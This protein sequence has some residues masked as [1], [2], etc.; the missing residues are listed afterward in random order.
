MN[1]N[2]SSYSRPHVVECIRTNAGDR[3]HAA[4]K[5]IVIT[6]GA[7]LASDV[8]KLQHGAGTDPHQIP[9]HPRGR[10]CARLVPYLA[11]LSVVGA[12]LQG[13]RSVRTTRCWPKGD[14]RVEVVADG[15]LLDAIG[16]PADFLAQYNQLHAAI[17]VQNL[18]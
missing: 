12:I 6:D 7:D 15:K 16:T 11:D 1:N 4:R 17:V 18:G 2:S 9:D 10:G 13:S 8:D 5:L 3:V 14:A